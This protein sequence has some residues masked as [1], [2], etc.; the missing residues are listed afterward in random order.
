M[1]SRAVLTEATSEGGRL[2]LKI[3]ER[4]TC[5]MKLI[6]SWDFK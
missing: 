1:I 5:L 2:A 6:V 4:P 3:I